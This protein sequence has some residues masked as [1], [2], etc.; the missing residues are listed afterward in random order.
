VTGAD[1]LVRVFWDLSV[2]SPR[3]L[4][5]TKPEQRQDSVGERYAPSSTDISNVGEL[6]HRLSRSAAHCSNQTAILRLVGL[7]GSRCS[8]WCTCCRR[9]FQD[10]SAK[11]R[12]LTSRL[13]SPLPL[14]LD[15]RDRLVD[16]ITCRLQRG[17]SL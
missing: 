14:L 16:V 17:D 1:V 10:R 6:G 12:S 9:Q 7:A 11:R 4:M 2:W 13:R 5:A 3:T 8:F 15:H